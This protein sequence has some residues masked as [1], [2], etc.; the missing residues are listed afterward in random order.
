MAGK[1][2]SRVGADGVGAARVSAKRKQSWFFAQLTGFTN[3][4]VVARYD[5]TQ[6]DEAARWSVY[7]KTVVPG[8]NSNDFEAKQV[9]GSVCVVCAAG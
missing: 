4:G 7:R 1:Q 3:P 5:F 2:L 6:K 8:L 9:C